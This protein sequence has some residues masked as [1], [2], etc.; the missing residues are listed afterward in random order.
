MKLTKTEF[1]ELFP[2]IEP[3]GSDALQKPMAGLVDPPSARTTPTFLSVDLVRAASRTLWQKVDARSTKKEARAKMLELLEWLS[4]K[5]GWKYQANAPQAYRQKS[6]HVEGRVHAL[7]SAGRREVA[8]ELCFELQESI[9][10]KLWAAHVQG[11]HVLLLWGGA[12]APDNVL[13]GRLSYWFNGQPMSWLHLEQL[14][15][16]VR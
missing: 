7:I 3:R 12:S 13:L 6:S 8:V 9:V 4:G 15:R 5:H 1:S 10:L 16:A 11:K 2:G 14:A